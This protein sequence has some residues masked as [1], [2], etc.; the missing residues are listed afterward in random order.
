M[1]NIDYVGT[2]PATKIKSIIPNSKSKNNLFLTYFKNAEDHKNLLKSSSEYQIIQSKA[3]T[4]NENYWQKMISSAAYFHVE[5]S[6][7][8]DVFAMV[9]N[10]NLKDEKSHTLSTFIITKHGC[11]VNPSIDVSPNSKY[12]P[13]IENL[14]EIHKSSKVRKALAIS[15]LKTFADFSNDL[16]ENLYKQANLSIDTF[17]WDETQAGL[18]AS[19][20]TLLDDRSPTDVGTF[21]YDLG[22]ITSNLS[23]SSYVVDVLYS[24][25]DNNENISEKNN[26]LAFLLGKQLEQLFDPLTEY[27]PEPTENVYKPPIIRNKDIPIGSNDDGQYPYD[28]NDDDHLIKSICSELIAVQTNYTVSLVQFLQNFIVPLRIQVLENKLPG[29]TTEKLNHIFPPTIDEV[30]RIN[31]IFLDMLKLAQPFGSYEILKACGT[32]IPYFYKAQ[33]RHEAAIKHFHSNYLQFKEQIEKLNRSDLL[34]FD[35]RTIETCVYS[36]LNLVKIQL[37]IQRLVKNKIWSKHLIE[38]VNIFEK[39]CNDTISSFA[40]D[41]LKPYNGRVFTPTGKILTEIA[42]GWPSELQYG[43]LTRRVVAV[44]DATDILANNV[45]DRSVIIVFSDHVL[46]LSIDDDEYYYNYWSNTQSIHKPSISD[47]LLHSLINETPLTQLPHMSVKSWSNI[48]DLNALYFTT[49]ITPDSTSKPNSFVRFFNDKNASFT[50]IYKLDKVSGKYVTEVLARS[51]ILNKSQSFH[52]FMGTISN[53]EISNLDDDNKDETSM[54]KKAGDNIVRRVYYTAHEASTYEK[55]STKSPFIVLFNQD[56]DE[57][58]LSKYNV[59]AF[60]TLNFINEDT[61]KLEC[62]SRCKFD[63]QEKVKLE[64]NIRADLLSASLSLILSELFATHISVYNPMMLDYLLTN[65]GNYNKNAFNV[66]SIPL[67][68]L[69]S[70][71]EKIIAQVKKNQEERRVVNEV[72][73]DKS[74]RRKSLELLSKDLNLKKKIKNQTNTKTNIISAPNQR[75]QHQEQ[76]LKTQKDSKGKKKTSNGF[77]S[78]FTLKKSKKHKTSSSKPKIVRLEEAPERKSSV[79]TKRVSINKHKKEFDY[80]DLKPAQPKVQRKRHSQSFSLFSNKKPESQVAKADGENIGGKQLDTGSNLK[81]TANQNNDNVKNDANINIHNSNDST[82]VSTSIYVNS[83]FE[84][85]MAPECEAVIDENNS[86]HAKTEVMP[87]LAKLNDTPKRVPAYK[88][89]VD[90]MGRL[91]TNLVKSNKVEKKIQNEVKNDIYDTD[92]FELS[93]PTSPVVEQQFNKDTPQA[94]N[95]AIKNKKIRSNNTAVKASSVEQHISPIK[96]TPWRQIALPKKIDAIQL[97]NNFSNIIQR[98]PSFYIRFKEMRENQENVLRAKGISYIPDVNKLPLKDRQVL[99]GGF[100]FSP[101][102]MSNLNKP[103][104][105]DDFPNWTKFETIAEDIKSIES[106]KDDITIVEKQLESVEIRSVTSPREPDFETVNS[107]KIRVVDPVIRVRNSSVETNTSS[108]YQSIEENELDK[109]GSA[110][111]RVCSGDNPY[112]TTAQKIYLDDID[113]LSTINIDEVALDKSEFNISRWDISSLK[114]TSI[115]NKDSKAGFNETEKAECLGVDDSSDFEIGQLTVGNLDASDFN[116]SIEEEEDSKTNLKKTK[117]LGTINDLSV[118]INSASSYAYLNDVFNGIYE[119]EPKTTS[120]VSV[121]VPNQMTDNTGISLNGGAEFDAKNAS[122]PVVIT[123]KQISNE[124]KNSMARDYT[125]Y[126]L[127]YHNGL[128][129]S[130]INYLSHYIN[131]EDVNP[132]VV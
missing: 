24:E 79:I 28:N 6:I 9:Y 45:K 113:F 86:P 66:L 15:L 17:D 4:Y 84:F 69:T 101:S 111:K 132:G 78:I 37:I 105:T 3:D 42:K 85:P 65:N 90:L 59:Y 5:N 35:Q 118:L 34:S 62:L 91:D 76:Q 74:D 11:S 25:Q 124:R 99:S 109:Y 97:D 92:L 10:N 87:R 16:V 131:N 39:S 49:C 51:K 75:P 1:S 18:L 48:N 20:M 119:E 23:T 70:D 7:L 63:G 130:S 53:D 110:E 72:S 58:L 19:E 64:Y 61:I 121:V 29:F 67:E 125:D 55:E 41:Q 47:I 126:D 82:T 100:V 123:E 73:N 46:F 32:T 93:N 115:S 26:A 60:I 96:E 43:W 127:V 95:D 103:S 44:F 38:N 8:G 129:S 83:H 81:A 14:S 102:I 112:A 116:T 80:S 22:Y 50:G 57:N 33:M 106:L 2:S 31:C 98:S 94:G 89:S 128:M 88:D 120:A 68:H 71:S 77:L 36:S 52:L 27:S 122:N 40:N 30:T 108:A 56:Y 104:D 107:P 21:L 54:K 12:Y 13:A 114:D 117:Q